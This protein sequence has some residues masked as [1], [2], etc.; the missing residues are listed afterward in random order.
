[1]ETTGRSYSLSSLLSVLATEDTVVQIVSSR[2]VMLL[3]IEPTSASASAA[4]TASNIE[5][6]VA[7]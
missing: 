2:A 6:L 5:T 7:H 4:T 3:A 1:M